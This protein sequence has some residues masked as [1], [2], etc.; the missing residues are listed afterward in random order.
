MQFRKLAAAAGSALMAGMALATPAIAAMANGY[1]SEI[2]DIPSVADGE[3][4]FP[5]FV[6]GAQAHAADVIAATN[7]GTWLAGFVGEEKTLS[8]TDGVVATAEGG[9]SLASSSTKIYMGDK[10][11]LAKV[12]IDDADMPNALAD[13]VHSDDSGNEITYT[14][15][16]DMTNTQAHFMYGGA[17]TSVDAAYYV[18]STAKSSVAAAAGLY[19]TKV[20]FSGAGLNLTH[21]DVQGSDLVL[22]GNKYTI[23]ST[24]TATKLVLYGA[25]ELVTMDKGETKT[26]TIGGEEHEITL[27][28]VTDVASSDNDKTYISID[29]GSQTDITQGVMKT[30]NGID[31]YAKTVIYT[32]KTGDLSSATFSMGSDKLTLENTKKAV[33]G[34]GSGSSV[35]GTYVAITGTKLTTLEI[36]TTIPETNAYVLEGTEFLDPVFGSFKFVFDTTSVPTTDENRE[37]IEIA[38]SGDYTQVAFIPYGETEIKTVN[39]AFDSGTSTTT[40]TLVLNHTEASGQY[41][42]MEGASAYEDDYIVVDAGGSSNIFKV[43]EIDTPYSGAVDA[44]DQCSSGDGVTL[45]NILTGKSVTF[46]YHDG[47]SNIT[48]QTVGG[49]PVKI[50]ATS[51]T[52]MQI[53]WTTGTR[54]EYETNPLTTSD[55]PTITT[56]GRHITVWPGIKT[57]TGAHI[58]FTKPTTITHTMYT[59]QRLLLPTGVIAIDSYNS[60]NN[61]NITYATG[62]ADAAVT[63]ST[64]ATNDSLGWDV[65]IGRQYYS[66]NFSAFAATAPTID[67][68]VSLA[69]GS[70][71]VNVTQPAILIKEQKNDNSQFETLIIQPS[72][73][74]SGAGTIA[75]PLSSGGAGAGTTTLG[76]WFTDTLYSDSKMYKYADLWGTIISRDTNTDGAM[77]ISIP[78]S[79]IYANLFFLEDEGTISQTASGNT[80]REAVPVT[81]DIAVL[82]TEITEADKTGKDLIVVGG[83]CV[84]SVAADL[85]G[86]EPNTCEEAS[87]IPMDSAIIKVFKDQYAEGK[88]AVLV[89]GW[90]KEDTE[91]AAR[92]IQTGKLDTVDETEVTIKGTTLSDLTIVEE[93]VADEPA[94]GDEE[95]DE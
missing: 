56:A 42:V 13:Q 65:Q 81:G 39:W 6:V 48:T 72:Q 46:E 77:E 74:S 69:T 64:V 7:L 91:L 35:D 87:G 3:P 49:V 92:A 21:T 75:V 52:E 51:E 32:S 61:T 53:Y 15:T 38:P 71:G 10:L 62:S 67:I 12:I 23:G 34:S 24:S 44:S 86:L 50:N 11:N 37:T 76:K 58:H 28:S 88:V 2:S 1:V 16:I 17:E 22:F 83:P 95:T 40:D 29:G 9:A 26:F 89:A 14:Q 59:Q 41:I 63:L 43:D 78:A 73:D 57:K 19:A 60:T 66:F 90:A 80:Y 36:D 54:Q 8:S 4:V 82:D 5:I 27:H 94:E 18:N 85:L 84:N 79:Q 55:S 33:K 47:C 93:V 68:T 70:D 20:S 25:G 45:E 31:V 30:I